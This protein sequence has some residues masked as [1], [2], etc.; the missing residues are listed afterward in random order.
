MAVFAF[1]G[2]AGQTATVTVT[3]QAAVQFQPE[4]WIATPGH[5]EYASGTHSWVSE[6]LG[7]ALGVLARDA[8]SSP[9][10]SVGVPHTVAYD[11]LQLVFVRDAGAGDPTD[12]FDIEVAVSN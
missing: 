1:V 2:A 11:G 6:E 8:A 7:T 12:T 9:G 4:V 10:T 3:P 5:R